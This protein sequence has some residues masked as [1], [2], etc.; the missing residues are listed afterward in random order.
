MQGQGDGAQVR[1]GVF[2]DIVPAF[3]AEEPRILSSF[4]PPCLHTTGVVPSD[5]KNMLYR[6][7]KDCVDWATS[8]LAEWPTPDIEGPRWDGYAV[9]KLATG[10]FRII[11]V[12]PHQKCYK[13]AQ[14]GML[15]HPRGKQCTCVFVIHRNPKPDLDGRR[16]RS[17]RYGQMQRGIWGSDK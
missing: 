7:F 16:L 14:A 17:L 15:S 12:K 3:L 8:A 13:R 9:L 6:M 10:S 2:P 5:L 1:R 11:T 4:P